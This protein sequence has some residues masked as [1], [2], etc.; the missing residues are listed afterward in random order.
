MKTETLGEKLES[1]DCRRDDKARR[2]SNVA[3]DTVADIT[4]DELENGVSLERLDGLN[5]PA[6][7]YSTQLTIHG[8]LPGFNPAARPGGYKAI[9]QNGNGSIGVRFAAIDAEKKAILRRVSRVAG[10]AWHAFANSTGFYLQRSFYVKNEGER[11]AQ[12]AAT[13][14]ALKNFPVS[15]FY[16]NA[17][18]YS[19]PYGIGYAVEVNLGAIPEPLGIHFKSVPRGTFVGFRGA[20]SDGSRKT[21]RKRCGLAC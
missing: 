9:F 12:R 13:V 14:D 19:L 20:G 11:A 16:G 4:A 21:G 3:P 6:L 10:A 8:K 5:V 1:I 7:R 2:V 18:A 15:L 17:G